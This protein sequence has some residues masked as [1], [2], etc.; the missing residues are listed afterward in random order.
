V[1]QIDLPLEMKKVH[2]K[3][4]HQLSATGT[5][6]DGSNLISKRDK[7]ANVP[8]SAC[9]TVLTGEATAVHQHTRNCT[10]RCVMRERGRDRGRE[11]GTEGGENEK[12]TEIAP[13]DIMLASPLEGEEGREGG[14]K[15]GRE[16][17]REILQ[18]VLKGRAIS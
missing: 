2:N 17:R 15:G 1:P 4:F 9:G 5:M 14:R 13:S 8:C 11:G 7:D 6:P 10:M 12:R 3:E 16:R 18:A